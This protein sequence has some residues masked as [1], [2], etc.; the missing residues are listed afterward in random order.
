M[1]SPV[2]AVVC[3]GPQTVQLATTQREK[4]QHVMLQVPELEKLFLRK[5]IRWNRTSE[6][7]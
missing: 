4:A 6:P 3:Y 5:P 2:I 7:C 1:G